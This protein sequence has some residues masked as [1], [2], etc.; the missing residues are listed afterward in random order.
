MAALRARKDKAQG[1]VSRAQKALES[2]Q[3]ELADVLAAERV[4]ADITG[5]SLEP[6][7]NESVASKRDIDIAR[8]VP[9][10]AELAMSP[11]ELRPLYVEETG[12]QISIETFRTALWRLQKKVIKGTEKTWI[13]KSENGKYWREP[14]PV[15]VDPF[16]FGDDEDA[17]ADALFK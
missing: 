5:E 8:I 16:A 9:A 15:A 4:L 13:I 1:K 3:N 11:A 14:A 7:T 2:A 17:D 12:D 10:E 6:K